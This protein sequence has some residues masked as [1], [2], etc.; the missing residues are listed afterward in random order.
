MEE[1]GIAVTLFQP[2][3]SKLLEPTAFP[4]RPEM[5]NLSHQ[6]PYLDQE[7]VNFFSVV[8]WLAVKQSVEIPLMCYKLSPGYTI[9]VVLPPGDL[10]FHH[11]EFSQSDPVVRLL[12]SHLLV[13]KFLRS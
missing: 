7:L 4:D 6:L 9:F 10:R 8:W 11:L 3:N 12:D 5:S 1:R 13:T 2:I